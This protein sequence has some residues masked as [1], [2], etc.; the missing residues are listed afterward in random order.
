MGKEADEEAQIAG[1]LWKALRC[2]RLMLGRDPKKEYEDK[3][4]EVDLAG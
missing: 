3:V 1:K 4:A 2:D